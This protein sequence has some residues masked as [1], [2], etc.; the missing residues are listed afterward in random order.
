MEGNLMSREGTFANSKHSKYKATDST[1]RVSKMQVRQRERK[2][3]DTSFFHKFASFGKNPVLNFLFNYRLS[4]LVNLIDFESNENYVGLDVGCGSGYISRYI[5]YQTGGT[6]VG[7]DL[8]KENLYR[9]KFRIE[10]GDLSH[11]KTEFLL[12][13][14]NHLPFRT[15]SFDLVFCASVFEHLKELRTALKE[16]KNSMTNNGS[17]VAGYPIE[18]VPFIVLIKLFKP[19]YM[20]IRDPK[21]LGKELFG[22]S[23]DTHKQSFT[24]I[25]NF[26]EEQFIVSA[27]QK[28]FFAILPDAISWYECAKMK[29]KMTSESL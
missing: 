3:S 14:I 2:K 7:I 17:L 23:P 9:G 26:L 1:S 8:S 22:K 21:I 4:L 12:A 6:V 11:T 10:W 18:M 19:D 28:S 24:T 15:N 13:D 25:R 27:R 20:K 29:K 5:A 16:I